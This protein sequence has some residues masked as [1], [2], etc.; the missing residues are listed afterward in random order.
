MAVIIEEGLAVE[1]AVLPC[2]DHGARLLLGRV[3]DGLDC[4]FND[5]RTEFAEQP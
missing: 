5:R 4:S 2:R 3:Q 1:H